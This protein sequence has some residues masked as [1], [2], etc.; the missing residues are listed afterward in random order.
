MWNP[1]VTGSTDRK[2]PFFFHCKTLNLAQILMDGWME[3][4]DGY[5]PDKHKDF[6]FHEP[7]FWDPNIQRNSLDVC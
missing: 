3:I 1:K 6:A 5:F 2:T 4:F 7:D